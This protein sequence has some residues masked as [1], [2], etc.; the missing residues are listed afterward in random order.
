MFE[1]YSISIF[2]TKTENGITCAFIEIYDE[3]LNI[4]IYKKTVFTKKEA[5]Y[6]HLEF[7]DFFTKEENHEIGLMII[8]TRLP[9]KSKRSYKPRPRVD[10]NSPQHETN[11]DS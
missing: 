1:K 7:L 3:F 2:K 11:L 4:S 10:H 8:E 5:M 6:F 9:K